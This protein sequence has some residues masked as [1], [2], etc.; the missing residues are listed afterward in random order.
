MEIMKIREIME[1]AAELKV[2]LEVEAKAGK[3]WGEQHIITSD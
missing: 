2:P 1:K 3:S